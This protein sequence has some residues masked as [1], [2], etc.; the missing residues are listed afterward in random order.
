MF[1]IEDFKK[2]DRVELHPATD[3][4]MRGACYGE[5][6]RIGRKHLYVN[7]DKHGGRS[8]KVSPS[9]VGRIVK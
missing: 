2:G 9:N 3:L 4:W 8:V 5:V 7:L 1:T 6:T